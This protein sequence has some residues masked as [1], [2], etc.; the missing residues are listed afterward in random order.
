[1]V[2]DVLEHHDPTSA[3]D[4]RLDRREHG[5]V[6]GRQRAPVQV[7]A[8]QGLEQRRVAH[9]DLAVVVGDERL[10]VGEPALGHQHRARHVPGPQRP[11]D[12]LRRLGDVEAALGL[13]D[14]AER[15]VGEPRV[16]GEGVVVEVG[17]AG[18]AHGAPGG[19]ARS[20]DRRG[21]EG[22]RRRLG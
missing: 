13:G 21:R 2:D 12:H 16:V 4:H 19:G 7:V 15:D 11:L 9:E 8:G 5:P 20:V 22:Q 14:A 6:H 1:V 3:L 17:D 18:D 10:D